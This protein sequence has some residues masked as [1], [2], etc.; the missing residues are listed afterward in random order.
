M[1]KKIEQKLN[2]WK[3]KLVELEKKLEVVMQ[4]RGEAAQMGDLS[5]NAAYQ[6]ASEEADVYQVRINEVKKIIR[7][8]EMK[9]ET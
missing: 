4:Q 6:F 3:K 7:D 2:M 5:E 9:K 1:D 8:L